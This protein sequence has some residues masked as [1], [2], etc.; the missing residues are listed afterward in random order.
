VTAEDVDDDLLTLGAHLGDPRRWLWVVDYDG[1]LAPIVDRPDDAV[2]APGAV[3]A[4]TA[5]ARVCEV[6]L[7]SGRG[8]DDLLARL[9]AVP[10]GA[11][12]VGG[13]G[14]EARLPDGTWRALTDLDAARAALDATEAELAGQLDEAD[15]WLVERKRTSLAV[16]HRRVAATEVE[17]HLPAVRATLE[18]ATPR[19]PGFAVM[20]GKAVLELKP[21]GV[22]KGAALRWIAGTS[23]GHPPVVLG[24]DVTDEDAFVTAAELGG[25]GVLIAEGPTDTAARFRLRDPSRVVTL[26]ESLHDQLDDDPEDGARHERWGGRR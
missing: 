5:L 24:D 14:S 13:H 6:A 9:G 25:E 10:E 8:L 17:A 18:R 26:L 15:G 20:A 16:H 3:E 12:I 21:R 22:D 4:I 1:T 23:S 2:P 11:L 19:D 7:L